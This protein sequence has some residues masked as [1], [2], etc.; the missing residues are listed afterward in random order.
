MDKSEAVAAAELAGG[1]AEEERLAGGF[2]VEDEALGFAGLR[3]VGI[4]GGE[5]GEG[6]ERGFL[7]EFFE[8][9][10]LRTGADAAAA[11]EDGLAA[12]GQFFDEGEKGV[13]LLFDEAF[14]VIED[15]EG[16]GATQLIEE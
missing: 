7:A 12:S 8:D 15:E 14:E 1:P 5:F 11:G 4:V 3:K 10:F 9:E 6:G 13:A 16:L 2:A